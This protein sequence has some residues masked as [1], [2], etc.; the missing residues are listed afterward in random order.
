MLSIIAAIWC[1]L[2]LYM[3]EFNGNGHLRRNYQTIE[4]FRE[5]EGHEQSSSIFTQVHSIK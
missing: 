4:K 2:L 1:E 3:I 5:G